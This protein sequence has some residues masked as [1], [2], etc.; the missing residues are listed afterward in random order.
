MVTAL[1][2][3]LAFFAYDH[4]ES[5]RIAGLFFAALGAGTLVGT[6]S[7]VFIVRRVAPL[8]L[9]AFGILAFAVPLWVLPLTSTA[10]GS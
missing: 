7:A 1:S 5:S 10:P 6:I 3:S 8:K 9:A 4:F 2:A